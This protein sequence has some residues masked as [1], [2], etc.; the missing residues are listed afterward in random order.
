[1][2]KGLYCIG[3]CLMGA[4]TFTAAESPLDGIESGKDLLRLLDQKA[5][6][7]PKA[8]DDVYYT[9]QVDPMANSIF[10]LVE[11]PV[12]KRFHG[13]RL[14]NGLIAPAILTGSRKTP[15]CIDRELTLHPARWDKT[16]QKL[17]CNLAQTELLDTE[18]VKKTQVAS[19]SVQGHS[20]IAVDA[21]GV[22]MHKGQYL[23]MKGMTARAQTVA[24]SEKRSGGMGSMTERMA[25]EGSLTAAE[26]EPMTAS[27][28]NAAGTMASD[29]RSAYVEQSRA[30]KQQS[31]YSGQAAPKKA[32]PYIYNPVRSAQN[33][34]TQFYVH[35][36]SGSRYGI[37]IGTWVKAELRTGVNSADSGDAELVLLQSITGTRKTLE[38]GTKLFASKTLNWGTERMDLSVSKVLTPGLDE[39]SISASVYDLGKR[40]GLSGILKR[41][42]KEEIKAM[43]GKA[44]L[45]TLGK[46]I[47]QGDTL[48]GGALTDL[49][50]DL[51]DQEEGYLAQVPRGT[52]D[53][54]P[55]MVFVKI[56]KSF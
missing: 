11:E 16:E 47:P 48:V 55:Q 54:A 33:T 49:G 51:V 27:K 42:R 2:V 9:R 3:L 40:E 20:A 41:R 25:K 30:A 24:S 5:S 31:R 17:I 44:A 22:P 50:G 13:M 53:V 52:I 43:G 39:F 7:N 8:L 10:Y 46:T 37:P 1:M 36:K 19:E 4:A 32:H 56:E 18:Q 45:K 23:A 26:S 14:P 35:E 21:Q 6:A 34:G 15:A 12:R 28:S 29:P 38:R